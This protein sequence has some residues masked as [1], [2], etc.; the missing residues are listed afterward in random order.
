MAG[1]A[2]PRVLGRYVLHGEIAAGGMASVHLG[3]LLGPVGF[4]RT[5]AIKRLHPQFAKDPEFVAM[6]LDEARIAA[7][8]RHPN[9]VPTLDVVASEGE[10]FL[11]MDYVEGES[12]ARLVRAS[13]R[14]GAPPSP[15]HVVAVMVGALHGLHAAHEAKGENG[16]PLGIVHRD[17]SPQNVLV[18]VD[19]VARVLDFGVAKALGRSQVTREGQLKGKLPYMAPEQIRRKGVVTRQTDVYAASVVL[20]EALTARRL[21]DGDDEAQVLA[22]V[23]DG[24]VDPPSHREPGLPVGLDALV[25][26]GLHHDPAKRFATA[27]DMALAL[28]ACVPPATTAE[29]A[30][31]VTAMAGQALETRAA[32]VHAIESNPDL[33]EP[34]VALPRAEPLSSEVLTDSDSATTRIAAASQASSVSVATPASTTLARRSS[35]IAYV[36]AAIALLS[37]ASV[38]VITLTR[39]GGETPVT[40]APAGAGVVASTPSTPTAVAT[41]SAPNVASSNAS[42]TTI[43]T[44]MGTPTA[45][46]TAA[47]TTDGGVKKSPRPP[48]TATATIKK[49]PAPTGACDP[50][51][52]Y[53]K[54]IK[55]FKPECI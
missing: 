3:R 52:Y 20:W 37:I 10:L 29:V 17:V 14:N 44:A 13:R 1:A 39:N 46:A 2:A 8:I 51:F 45:I 19:G 7:R 48:S 32:W 15:H 11:V 31:W 42:A 38:A 22:A 53:D 41:G 47:T 25:L 28:E 33:A 50:P 30:A 36:V 43:T 16:Q 55:K 49:P 23:L 54:G 26:R 40:N 4:S 6:F 24:H 18:G 12:L 21:F 5:V 9:V 35:P 34:T 27:R